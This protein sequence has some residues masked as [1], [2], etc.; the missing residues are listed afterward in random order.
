MVVVAVVRLH[1]S[2]DGCGGGD[3]H[4]GFDDDCRDEDGD[5]KINIF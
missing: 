5:E 1:D 2:D 4:C 3:N